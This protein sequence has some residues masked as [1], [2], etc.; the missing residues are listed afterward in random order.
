MLKYS[1]ILN[2]NNQYYSKFGYVFNLCNTKDP[3]VHWIS[4]FID[5]KKKTIFYFDSI[6][7]FPK[8]DIIINLKQYDL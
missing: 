5:N 2:N 3:G 6:A 4:L 7:D 8:Q 1:N